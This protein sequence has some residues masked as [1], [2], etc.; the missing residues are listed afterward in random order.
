M[1]VFFIKVFKIRLFLMSFNGRQWSHKDVIRV[2]FLPHLTLFA[3]KMTQN[4]HTNEY[5]Y[6]IKKRGSITL[7]LKRVHYTPSENVKV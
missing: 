4:C 5:Q 6:Q 1:G 7:P 2:T 3:T